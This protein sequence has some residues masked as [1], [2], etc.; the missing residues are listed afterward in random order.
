MGI[1]KVT[2]LNTKEEKA[3]YIYQ[4]IKDIEAL[5]IMIKEGLIE[6][7]PIRIG[8]EQEFCLVNNDFLPKNNSLDILKEIDD[9]HFTTEIGNYNLEINLRPI[10]LKGDCFS[11]LHHQLS[12]LLKK[13]KI[14]AE[15]KDTK[16]ILTGM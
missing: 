14:S 2:K 11:E 15:K 3:S 8:V 10:K 6:K 4:L 13:A 7:K 12:S 16:I 5:D 9:D 1:L